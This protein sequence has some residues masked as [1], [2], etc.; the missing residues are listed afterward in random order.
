MQVYPFN[1]EY[2]FGGTY[3]VK[4]GVLFAA[5]NGDDFLHQCNRKPDAVKLGLFQL[6]VSLA[7]F[8]R[9][10]TSSHKIMDSGEHECKQPGC[11]IGRLYL[12]TI[13]INYCVAL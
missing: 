13:K 3:R 2:H 8:D 4:R 11:D 5:D 9:E 10:F 7:V 1:A 6:K 12:Q